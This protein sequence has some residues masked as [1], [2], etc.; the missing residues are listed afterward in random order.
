MVEQTAAEGVSSSDRLCFVVEAPTSSQRCF[1]SLTRTRDRPWM[2][3]M[4]RAK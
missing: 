4:K 3:Q 2:A 1:Q